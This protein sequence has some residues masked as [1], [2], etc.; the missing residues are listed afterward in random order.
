MCTESVHPFNKTLVLNAT[1]D[2][3]PDLDLLWVK[4]SKS[5]NVDLMKMAETGGKEWTVIVSDRQTEGRG[6]HKRPW[7]NSK[8]G[9]YF[10]VL[11]RLHKESPPI[12]L[13]PLVI[14]LAL[15]EAIQELAEERGR[16]IQS[17]L[18]W[19][20]DLLTSNGKLAGILCETAMDKKSG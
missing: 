19:P 4:T 7:V 15:Q 6:R 16:G 8:N 13:I 10:S 2:S 3:I 1:K 17:W 18:K 9:L 5:T 20:N 12:T 11:L 14:G